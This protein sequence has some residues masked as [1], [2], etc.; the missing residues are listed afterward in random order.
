[1][2]SNHSSSKVLPNRVVVNGLQSTV[3]NEGQAEDHHSALNEGVQLGEAE[4]RNRPL[5]TRVLQQVFKL[6]CLS[7]RLCPQSRRFMTAG[8]KQSAES[9]ENGVG[10]EEGGRSV[11]PMAN[12]Y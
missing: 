6:E 9:H 11:I 8:V 2:P 5:K 3:T 10:G 4:L 12:S 7:R 1:M